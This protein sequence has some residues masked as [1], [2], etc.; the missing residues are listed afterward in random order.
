[1]TPDEPAPEAV[2]P[3]GII[4]PQ[5]FAIETVEIRAPKYVIE[6]Y[7]YETIGT[8]ETDI[9]GLA[10][11]LTA[12]DDCEPYVSTQGKTFQE[13]GSHGYT[14]IPVLEFLWG[15]PLCNAV[16][17]YVCGLRPS[18]V[19][20]TS[21]ECTTDACPQRVTIFVKPKNDQ[22]AKLG[23]ALDQFLVESIDQ[24]INVGY[25]C[26]AD[27][28]MIRRAIQEGREPPAKRYDGPIGHASALSQADFS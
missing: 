12:V 10:R 16:M 27:V 7:A 26:G 1:M 9:S 6:F 28:D 4:L 8:G 17:A 3:G 24:E 21:G 23:G 19:R 18:K 13:P 5:G 20:I 25:S 2:S 14:T 22:V 15:M 11:K